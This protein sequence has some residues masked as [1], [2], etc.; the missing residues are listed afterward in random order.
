MDSRST[1]L[2]QNAIAVCFNDVAKYWREEYYK[3]I[4]E[5]GVEH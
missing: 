4:F 1:E 3:Y 2:K 5:G